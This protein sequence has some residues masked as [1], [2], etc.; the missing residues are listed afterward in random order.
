[1]QSL[2]QDIGD[3][4]IAIDILNQR[5]V[6]NQVKEIIALYIDSAAICLSMLEDCE[7]KDM[8]SELLAFSS[9]RIY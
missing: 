8:L 4:Q 9:K 6:F 2:N 7:A 3:L 5:D 1:M